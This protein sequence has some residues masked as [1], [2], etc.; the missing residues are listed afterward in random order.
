MPTYA[1]LRCS[2]EI[3][4]SP[5]DAV[6]CNALADV[7]FQEGARCLSCAAEFSGTPLTNE[8]EAA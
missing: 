2:A 8:S 5:F 3:P 6:L 7:I 4:V 1:P